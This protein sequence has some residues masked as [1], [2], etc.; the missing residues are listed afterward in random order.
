MP[1]VPDL[2]RQPRGDCRPAVEE[3]VQAAGCGDRGADA[4]CARGLRSADRR[5]LAT[6]EAVIPYAVGVDIACRMKMTVLDVPVSASRTI[7]HV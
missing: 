6:N 7:R 1:G 4:R 2:G 3:R 5:R